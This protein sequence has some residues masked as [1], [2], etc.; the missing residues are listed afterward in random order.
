[1]GI[2]FKDINIEGALKKLRENF[3]VEPISKVLVLKNVLS[4]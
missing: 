3:Y 4:K 1:M 2:F